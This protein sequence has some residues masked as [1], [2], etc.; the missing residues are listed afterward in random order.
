MGLEPL[1][2]SLF[3]FCKVLQWFGSCDGWEWHEMELI[4]INSPYKGLLIK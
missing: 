1:Q 2:D 4:D 3:G